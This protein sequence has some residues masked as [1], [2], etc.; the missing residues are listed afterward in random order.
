MNAKI[1]SNPWK[2]AVWKVQDGW[3]DRDVPNV[4]WSTRRE[5]R[6]ARRNRLGKTVPTTTYS[7]APKSHQT[8]PDL[9]SL[10][11]RL[12][13]RMTILQDVDLVDAV[14]AVRT[15]GYNKAASYGH[16]RAAGATHTEAVSVVERN[17]PAFSLAYGKERAAGVTHGASYAR[18]LIVSGMS[19][20]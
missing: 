2:Q 15:W 9:T 14:Y 20:V 17:D 6:L 13:N 7:T 8:V 4:Y 1:L 16:I 3:I 11:K 19:A 10:Q 12:V 18:A 5:A